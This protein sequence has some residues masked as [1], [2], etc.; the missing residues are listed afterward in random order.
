MSLPFGDLLWSEGASRAD[1]SPRELELEEEEEAAR[2]LSSTFAR[3]TEREIPLVDLKFRADATSS[4]I[5]DRKP[6]GIAGERT[7]QGHEIL[8][9]ELLT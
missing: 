4:K 6:E 5:G 1:S 3:G 2:R 9:V 8:A 7:L